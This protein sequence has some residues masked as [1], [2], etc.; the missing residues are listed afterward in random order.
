MCWQYT[1]ISKGMYYK[2]W[3]T[4]DVPDFLLQCRQQATLFYVCFGL[5]VCYYCLVHAH[6]TSTLLTTLMG[7]KGVTTMYHHC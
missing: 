3:L 6:G 4:N 7:I 1:A 5:Q 2:P